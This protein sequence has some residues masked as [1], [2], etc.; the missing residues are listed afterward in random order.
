MEK[1][2]IYEQRFGVV[3]AKKIASI[4]SEQCNNTTLC[5]RFFMLVIF[6]MRKHCK[7]FVQNKRLDLSS[8]FQVI[9]L[10]IRLTALRQLD[11]CAILGWPDEVLINLWDSK[12]QASSC[13]LIGAS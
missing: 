1:S 8:C 12:L 5:C 6:P 3:S 11:D 7:N 9:A 2:C 13:P 10:D 4:C